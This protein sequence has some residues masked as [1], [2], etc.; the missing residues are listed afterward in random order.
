VL[1]AVVAMASGQQVLVLLPAP[2][3]FM[4]IYASMDIL[5]YEHICYVWDLFFVDGWKV[6]FRIA[7]ALL[8]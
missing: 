3:W 8:R 5:P 4:T 1:V 7:L 2:G 6:L